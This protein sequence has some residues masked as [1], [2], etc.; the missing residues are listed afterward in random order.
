M[1][2]LKTFTTKAG[3]YELA[4]AA[5]SMKAALE[6]WGTTRNI[7]ASG[8][9]QISQDKAVI[10]AA[11]ARPGVVLRRPL[12][13]KS[14]FKEK[15]VDIAVPPAPKGAKK[16]PR[17]DHAFIKRGERALARE[18]KAH[19]ARMAA[20]DDE[21]RLLDQKQERETKRWQ[22]VRASLE[23]ALENAKRG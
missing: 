18:E 11:I 14:E 12:G 15:P 21:R 5:P 22:G 19:D 1:R 17:R 9:A 3:F 8:E 10:A 23:T 13:S 16:I 4:L 6:A 2:T 7:F 20:I